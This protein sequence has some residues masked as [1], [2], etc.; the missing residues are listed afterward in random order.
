MYLIV[1]LGNPEEQYANTRHNMGFCA[2]NKLSEKYNINLDKSK[3][4]AIYGKGEIYG[5]KVIIVKP[6]TYMNLSG[7]AVKKFVDYYKIENDKILIIYDDM[8][9]EMGNIR[10]R[11]QGSSGSH[12]GMR[13]VVSM[14]GTEKI[15][16]IRIGISK[17]ENPN[18]NIDYVIGKVS[19][20]EIEKLEPGIKKAEDAICDI[21]KSGIDIAMN[22]Y[23]NK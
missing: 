18:N 16:R 6:Q 5:E 14:L 22:K 15:P 10:V 13:S 8:D 23:N 11:K 17:P 20:E 4:N 12:N 21:I 1:G 7:E 3:F 19:K 9:V 2:V